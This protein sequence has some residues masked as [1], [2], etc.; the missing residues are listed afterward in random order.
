[1]SP[2]PCEGTRP[3]PPRPRGPPEDP[4]PKYHG[5]TPNS[6]TWTEF[7]AQPKVPPPHP[8]TTSP[9]TPSARTPKAPPGGHP[10]FGDTFG[11]TFSLPYGEPAAGAVQCHPPGAVTAPVT[12]E[13]TGA[14]ERAGSRAKSPLP[15]GI[16][17]PPKTSPGLF[18]R[19][20]ILGCPPP[21][22]WE[23]NRRRK[24]WGRCRRWRNRT[25]RFGGRTRCF[26][27][28]GGLELPPPPK[29]SAVLWEK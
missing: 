13:I 28:W 16:W 5:F 19:G 18:L 25:P 9:Q 4:A 1:M 10:G 27:A 11:D 6:T 22:P 29:P 3:R 17:G 21:P 7:T 26:G 24:P 14:R 12:P 23:G 15:G 2:P 8:K 20:H